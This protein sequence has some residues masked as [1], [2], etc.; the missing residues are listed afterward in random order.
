MVIEELDDEGRVVAEP[1]LQM[2][3]SRGGASQ[4]TW[5][6]VDNDTGQTSAEPLRDNGPTAENP[7]NE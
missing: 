1:C 7:R 2:V 5:Q 6:T 4:S 3:P